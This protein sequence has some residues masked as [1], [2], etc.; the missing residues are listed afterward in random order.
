M[1]KILLLLALSVSLGTAQAE[2]TATH[3][4]AI[5][6]LLVVLQVQKQM[7]TN[8]VT[9][10]ETGL[11]AS[12]EQIKLLPEEKRQQYVKAFEK[13]KALLVESM[14]WEKLKPDIVEIYGKNFSEEEAT[15]ISAHMSTPAGQKF[16]ATQI[17]L[18]AD[19]MKIS[20]ERMKTLTPQIIEI[21]KTEMAK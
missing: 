6:K 14:G 10:L 17:T 1:K 7:E 21:M 9:G 15:A 11:G 19:M 13:V 16:V 4:A 12:S 2:L 20:Q 8:L 3:K 5:E 18:A